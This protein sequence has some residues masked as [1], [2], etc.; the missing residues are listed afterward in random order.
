[1]NQVIRSTTVLAI[2][3]DGMI[4]MASDGQV[5]VGDAVIKQTAQK[6]RKAAKHDVLIGFAG[7]AADALALTERLESKLEEYSGNVRRAAVELAKS[8][9]TDRALR[10][11]E[12]LLLLGNSECVLVV[13][14]NGD[15]IQ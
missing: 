9:R 3:R 8:W 5:T 4:A 13:S 14:G 1:M 12:A 15:L 11:L 7:G 6:T 10:R 2:V